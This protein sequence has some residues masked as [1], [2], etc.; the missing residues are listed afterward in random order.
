[1]SPESVAL[2]E[3][4]ARSIEPFAVFFAEKTRIGPGLFQN[5]S[6]L[7]P[8]LIVFSHSLQ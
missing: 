4:E 6:Q 2:P 3:M 1:M 8:H 5:R 7:C